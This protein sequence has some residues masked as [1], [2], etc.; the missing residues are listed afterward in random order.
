MV[1][2]DKEYQ[3]VYFHEYCKTCKYEKANP[4]KEDNPCDECLEN[5]MNLYTHKP[6]K[7]KPKK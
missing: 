1:T 3:E 6:V 7:W 2:E 4:Y 5:Y